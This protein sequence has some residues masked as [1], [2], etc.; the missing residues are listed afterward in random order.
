MTRIALGTAGLAAV[1]LLVLTSLEPADVV[2]GLA[3]GLLIAVALTP[4]GGEPRRAAPLPLRARALA[5]TVWDT[6]LEMARG[7]WRVIRFALGPRGASEPGFVEI[8]LEDR[9]RFEVALWGLVTGEAPDEY[10]VEADTERGVLLVH[11]ID[12]RD[13]DG[14]RARHHANHVRRHRQVVP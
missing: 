13:P 2:T 4:R 11:L 5:S 8:P 7:S 1:Y 14:V 6:A 9:D 10:P 12:A 3:V